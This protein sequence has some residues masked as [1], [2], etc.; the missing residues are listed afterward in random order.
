MDLPKFRYHPN[1]IQTG[2]V[3]A[4]DQECICCG[5]TRGYI[6]TGPVYA[7]EDLDDALCPWCIADGSA[8]EK[9][10]ADFVDADGVGGNGGWDEV[11]MEVIE[12][13]CHRTPSF[14]AWQ[15]ERWWTHCGDAAEF[16]G[17]VG[18]E[19]AIQAGK[20]FLSQIRE[21]MGMEEDEDWANF[22]DAL[23]RD[24]SP[25]AYMFRCRHCGKLG[26]YSDCD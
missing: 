20:D 2:S 13:V 25:T 5:Q 17:A 8:H 12:E 19:E 4:S 22:L 24:Q 9:F 3:I 11:P 21:E 1:P 10:D 15:Q 26:G 18:K 14:T 23:D 6:Y 7:E 16:L